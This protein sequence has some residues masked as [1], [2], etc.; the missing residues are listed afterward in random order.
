[1]TGSYWA[2]AVSEA[3]P[4]A[5]D[6]PQSGGYWNEAT[7]PPPR[8]G[9][10]TELRN[11]SPT[12][13][14]ARTMGLP[15]QEGGAGLGTVAATSF[16]T[17]REQARRIAASRLFPNLPPTEA[18]ARVF[19]GDDGRLA[20]VGE[21]GVPRY[22]E[23]NTLGR[24]GVRNVPAWVASGAGGVPAMAG[25][26]AGGAVGGSTTLVAGPA[27][28][29]A[30]AAAGDAARQG[31]A[32]YLDPGDA[33]TGEGAGYNIGQTAR[34]AGLAAAG[35]LAG[36]LVNRAMA[37]NA[38]RIPERDVGQV[39]RN[40]GVTQAG[41]AAHEN[42]AAQGVDLSTGQATGLPSLLTM[43]DAAMRNPATMDRATQFYTQQGAQMQGAAQR[44]LSGISPVDDITQASQGF[45]EA[46]GEVP[47]VVRRQANAAARP[48]Y[49]AAENAGQV[50]SPDLAAMMD[51]P[52]IQ[53]AMQRAR[54]T[55]RIAYQRA[56]P[57][58]P[59]FRLWDLTRRELGDLGREARQAG[60]RTI[61]SSYE[62]V[63]SNLS[64]RLDDAYPT[65]ARARA[66]AAPGQRLAATLEDTATGAAGG[67]GV[68]DRARQILA[69]IFERANPQYVRQARDAF[70]QAGRG[71][72]WNAGIRAYLQDAIARASTSQAGLNPA[73]LR[74]QIW[75]N[76]ED[77]VRANMQAAM[78]PEQFAGFNR[79]MQT[80]E[81]VARTFPQNSL[82]VQRLGGQEA[83][84]AAGEDGANRLLRGVGR[85]LSPDVANVVRDG[86]NRV[87]DWRN[88]RNVSAVIDNLFSRDG[89]QYLEQMARLNPSSR[90]AIVATGQFLARGAGAG[91][92]PQPPEQ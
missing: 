32:S 59:D 24:G 79:F 48:A 7:Q 71:E 54:E 31:V 45:R 35:Q 47:G 63:L 18:Q 17:D 46:A 40:P 41:R 78:T 77:G 67:A 52:A 10:Y 73:M 89:L 29:A 13:P 81:Q 27:A 50:V 82:T 74:R 22:V 49:Q 57:D 87:A 85:T 66:T 4:P 9:R 1:L 72:E 14:V 5:N 51:N 64:G 86:L 92:A 61:A 42:A 23:A 21:D 34:E 53:Q 75:A 16:A 30:G 36:A 20:A 90:G 60:R 37:P 6:E 38:L 70:F 56:A 88:Q 55:Y 80:V 25:G 44:M 84:R 8:P 65:Y 39:A 62:D 26:I 69:P 76:V 2:Q 11:P 91:E 28:A 33:F 19:Y 68:D 58:T 3:Q 15:I 83:M 12:N 43:E